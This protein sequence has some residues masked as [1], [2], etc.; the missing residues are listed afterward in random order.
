MF[1]QRLLAVLVE[2]AGRIDDGLGRAV[3]HAEVGLL[4]RRD[5]GDHARAP[6]RAEFDRR[7]ADAAG[8][9][10]HQQGLALL[11]F[12]AVLQRVMR[13]AVGH[14]EGARPRRR[15]W[16]P[17]S[18]PTRV[19]STATFVAMPPQPIEASMRSPT[20][21]LV[22]PCPTADND[23]GDLAARRERPARLELIQV[24]DDERVGI[25]DAAG[26]HVDD[27]MAR[28]ALPDRACPRDAGL[29][30]HPLRD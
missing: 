10:Q 20:L 28:A 14:E 9:A 11:E 25:V 27:D 26:L 19:A 24:L 6:G 8:R 5:G 12:R 7:D 16:R 29:P 13:G 17:E 23:A 3:L 22:T 18:S 1:G 2:R 21:R 4:L 30:G 15:A